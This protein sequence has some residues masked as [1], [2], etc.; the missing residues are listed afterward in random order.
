MTS[1]PNWLG[2]PYPPASPIGSETYIRDK[3]IQWRVLE[4]PA[5]EQESENKRTGSKTPQTLQVITAG[6]S[7]L[8]K[9]WIALVG[10]G[11]SIGAL[12][13]GLVGLGWGPFGIV[14]QPRPLQ[15]AVLSASA[16][17]VAT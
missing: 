5:E 3:L 4:D 1:M 14:E 11:F 9:F 15:Q 16:A 13:Q 2:A 6:A 8:S 17:I 12:F 10:S 7:Q